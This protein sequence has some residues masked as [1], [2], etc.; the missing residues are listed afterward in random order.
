MNEP[1][2]S[3]LNI[4]KYADEQQLAIEKYN[5]FKI[6]TEEIDTRIE[7]LVINDSFFDDVFSDRKVG[8]DLYPAIAAVQIF[9]I[10]YL[11]FFYT[12]MTEV[13]ADL[14]ETTKYF[15]FS[16]D[17]VIGVF[18]H[19]GV[20]IVE[21]YISIFSAS[22]SKKMIIKYVWTLI[23]FAL[24]C[25]FIYYLAPFK[26]QLNSTSNLYSPSRALIAFSFFYFIYFY[27]SALQIKYGFK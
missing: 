7:K 1:S 16:S 24:F 17:M 19:V 25:W 21:R 15:Q 26:K 5:P 23:I 22:R 9:L 14:A 8:V 3:K 20:M 6:A 4:W 13:G 2:K 11:I 12:Y 27:L 18:V 10:I